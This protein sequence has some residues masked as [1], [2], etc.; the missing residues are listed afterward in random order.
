MVCSVTVGNA[1][2]LHREVENVLKC[3]LPG[4]KSSAML[5]GALSA[6]ELISMI[7]FF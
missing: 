6:L 1:F 3:F 5:D 4:Q 7:I 2:N